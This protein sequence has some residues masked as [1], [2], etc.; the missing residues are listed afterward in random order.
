MVLL[1]DCQSE[2]GADVW[3]D[4]GY[5][6]CL[7]HLSTSRAGTNQKVL[8]LEKTFFSVNRAQHSKLPS[9]ISTMRKIKYQSY[10]NF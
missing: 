5:L 3:R 10:I 1:L 2:I 7:R 8:F 4:V 9:N 6:I